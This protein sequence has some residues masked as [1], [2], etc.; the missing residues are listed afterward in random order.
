MRASGEAMVSVLVEA[1]EASAK[2]SCMALSS[3]RK[4]TFKGENSGSAESR[5]LGSS[6]ST[7]KASRMRMKSGRSELE[8][9]TLAL[10]SA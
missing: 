8:S 9:L 2:R 4:K 10:W 6:A 1:D 3:G 7:L 5:T